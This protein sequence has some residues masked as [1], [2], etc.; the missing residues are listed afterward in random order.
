[1]ELLEI[2]TLSH[3][4]LV[5]KENLQTVIADGKSGFTVTSDIAITLTHIARG[6]QISNRKLKFIKK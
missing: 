4:P 6:R 3:N 1:M 5:F 2:K